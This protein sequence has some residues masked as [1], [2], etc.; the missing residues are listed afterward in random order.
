MAEARRWPAAAV[1]ALLLELAAAP[2]CARMVTLSEPNEAYLDAMA[3]ATRHAHHGRLEE[4]VRAYGRAAGVADRRVDRDEARYRQAKALQELGRTEEALVVLEDLAA[5]RPPS[6]RTARSCFDAALIRHQRGH[7][8]RALTGFRQ[9]VD[10]HPDSGLGG[11]ALYYLLDHHREHDDV[12]GALRLLES[13]Y[14]ELRD[15]TLGDD[16]LH[17]RA[18]LLLA[19]GDRDGARATLE[20]LVE[21]HPYPQGHRWDDALVEL[22]DMAE[23]DGDPE[24]AIGYLESLVQRR[25]TTTM[26]G[27]YTLP[28]MPKAQ[29]R[30][31]RLYRDAV[32]DAEAAAAAF[33]R[34]AADY[35]RSILRDDA[36][37]E[38]GV[39]RL[40]QDRRGEACDLF[41]RVTREYE[42]GHARRKARAHLKEHCGRP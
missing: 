40:E 37:F 25:D 32:G 22:A 13:L 39:L 28:S 30:I 35:P 3:E 9:V 12:D 29:L 20:T 5:A 16:V 1:L 2:G 38:L 18:R 10:E 26:V 15:T 21:N 7:R 33:E 4:A 6:R 24:R 31:A 27:S 19:R 36:L 42:V 11:R 41:E 23:E 17:H 14:P 34:M 8:E